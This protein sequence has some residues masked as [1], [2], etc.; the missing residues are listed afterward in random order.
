ALSAFEQVVRMDSTFSP[1]YE[2]LSEIAVRLGDRERARRYAPRVRSLTE[3]PP[4]RLAV[5]LRFGGARERA[6]AMAALDTAMRSTVSSVVRVFPFAPA[7]GDPLGALRMR[8]QELDDRRW[9]AGYR[10]AAHA[11]QGRW[12]QGLGI[13]QTVPPAEF[14]KWI[15]HAHLAG[16]RTKWAE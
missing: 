7:T 8:R 11:A 4:Y 12:A 15:V 1:V 13:W 14:D 3:G 16:Y 6:D 5:A 2:H 9:G 10:L